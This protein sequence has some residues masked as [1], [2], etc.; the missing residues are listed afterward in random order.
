MKRYH[1]YPYLL[2]CY[3]VV[4]GK[5]GHVQDNTQHLVQRYQG[6][7]VEKEANQRG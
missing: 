2:D 7:L 4:S 6:L 1:A 3:P 5:N